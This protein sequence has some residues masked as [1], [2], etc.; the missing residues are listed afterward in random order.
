MMPEVLKSASELRKWRE[1][2]GSV[3]LV[4]TMG[5]LHAGHLSLA[6]VAAEHAGSVVVSIFVNPTQ[7]GPNEDFDRYP[8]T[9]DADLQALSTHS[10]DAVFVPSIQE[11]YPDFPEP[12]GVTL[13]VGRVAEILDG[14]KR[15]GHFD[16]VVQVVAKLFNLVGPQV[17]VFGRKDAQ[18][19]AVIRQMVRDLNFP[20]DIVGAPIIRESDGL[21][22]SSRNEYLTPEQRAAATTLFHALQAGTALAND[23]AELAAA[24]GAWRVMEEH[25]LVTPEYAA[26]VNTADFSLVSLATTRGVEHFGPV[27]ADATLLVAAQLGDT[28]LIDNWQWKAR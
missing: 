25:H 27:E 10:V 7:F 15:P 26:V 24:A 19:L 21:A 8:R 5:A 11:M 20:I 28:R 4:P 14:A 13:H 18:Q 17:A 12:A 1:Q 22:M 3:A 16:G 2:R 23:G 9:L 6:D